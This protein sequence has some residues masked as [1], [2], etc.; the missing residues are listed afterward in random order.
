MPLLSWASW[1]TQWSDY[2]RKEKHGTFDR[3]YSL[4]FPKSWLLH[5]LASGNLG[6]FLCKMRALHR[7]A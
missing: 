6:F 3:G 4:L 2:I 5:P 7:A 1:G